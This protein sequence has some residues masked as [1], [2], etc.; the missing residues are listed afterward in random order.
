MGVVARNA[1]MSGR[2]PYE[3]SALDD[4][5]APKKGQRVLEVT[6]D[7]DCTSGGWLAH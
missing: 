5:L 6:K 2:L 3:S 4:W 7:D 1:A